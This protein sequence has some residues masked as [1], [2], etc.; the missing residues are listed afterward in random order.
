MA[1]PFLLIGE[2]ALERGGQVPQVVPFGLRSVESR[3][4]RK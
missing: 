2:E 1:R 3:Q 4:R